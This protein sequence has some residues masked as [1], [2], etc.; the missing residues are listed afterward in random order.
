[1]KKDTFTLDHFLSAK[2]RRELSD[3][4]R[5]SFGVQS[6]FISGL[7]L[8]SLRHTYLIPC[9]VKSQ[10]GCMHSP[11][12]REAIALD[13]RSHVVGCA[14]GYTFGFIPVRAAGRLLAYLEIG[15]FFVDRSQKEAF[16]ARRPELRISD[17]QWPILSQPAQGA[18]AMLEQWLETTVRHREDQHAL[19]KKDTLLLFLVDSTKSIATM[20]DTE[21]LLTYLTDA[22]T[23]LTDAYSGFIMSLDE[24]SNQLKIAVARGVSSD[25]NRNYRVPVGKGVTGWVA[26]HGEPL[27]VPDTARDSRYLG[28]GY[29]AQSELA[30]PIRSG[31]RL[32]GVLAVDSLERDA[33]SEN[34]RKM[35]ESL[36]LQVAHVMEA[37][38]EEK[39][40]RQKL[41]QLEAL[42]S[43]AQA[44]TSTLDLDEIL[45]AVIKQLTHV[46][47]AAG[48]AILLSDG[49]V[50]EMMVHVPEDEGIKRIQNLKLESDRGLL[51]YM[52]RERRPLLLH[53]DDGENFDR[54][55]RFL[56]SDISSARR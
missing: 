18:M 21:E 32:I 43:V 42:H 55:R 37:V 15:P 5:N 50:G 52:V 53:E 46:F 13:G 41:R 3:L 29:H 17:A 4:V 12:T 8:E 26:Q 34:D 38:Q 40:G 56:S 51:G 54:F 33:F 27:Y 16:F 49:N 14:A 9:P 6:R 2:D 47:S 25:F 10:I 36:A 39:Q 11:C 19:A 48:C 1:M 31:R 44:I 30:V 24:R 28:V 22:S 45:E 20:G 35:L 7:E 23:F